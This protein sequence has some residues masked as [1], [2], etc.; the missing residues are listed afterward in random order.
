MS[1]LLDNEK[2]VYP[3]LPVC[4][5]CLQDKNEIMLL[6]RVGRK[7][8]QATGKRDVGRNVIFDMTPCTTCQEQQQ[9]GIM[10][11]SVTGESL[12][13]YAVAQANNRNLDPNNRLHKDLYQHV[14]PER[15]GPMCVIKDDVIPRMVNSPELAEGILRQ[16][17]CILD[18]E[19]WDRLGFPRGPLPQVSQWSW[20][21]RKR[22]KMRAFLG[23]KAVRGVVRKNMKEGTNQKWRRVNTSTA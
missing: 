17:V 12:D 9:M 20:R 16:R 2:G 10:C 19:T 21:F 22:R 3:A 1:L 6:G 14:I 7:I 11:V 15:T 23:R 8:E 5:W 13:R 18:D 4:W